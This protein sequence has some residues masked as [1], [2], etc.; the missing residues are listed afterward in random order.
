MAQ[1]ETA[2]DVPLSLVRVHTDAR[3]RAVV[4]GLGVRAFTYGLHIY[5][6][7]QASVNDV[8]LMA[9]EIAHVIQQQGRP[10]LQM[11]SLSSRDAFEH[12]AHR[13]SG[14]VQQGRRATVEK[15]TGG[16]RVQGF[17]PVSQI[18]DWIEDRAWSL[19]NRFVPGLVPIIRKG[20]LQWLKEKSLPRL[21][22]SSTL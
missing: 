12:E 18:V 16:A 20:P 7:P 13:V 11:Y 1:L 9:H 3:T 15:R 19:V 10:V 5:L 22:A 6:G 8:A 17:W 2:L 21:R 14:D 4:D